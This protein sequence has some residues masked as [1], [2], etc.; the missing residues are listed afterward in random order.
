[1]NV[2]IKNLIYARKQMGLTIKEVEKVIPSISTI[3]S[4]KNKFNF[5]ELALLSEMYCIPDWI[6][7]YDRFPKEYCYKEKESFKNLE[8][9]KN[10]DTY[11][12]RKLI[13]KVEGLR[14][15]ILELKD[16]TSINLP[17]FNPPHL[18]YK[19]LFLENILEWL[20]ITKEFPFSFYKLKRSLE[21]RGVFVFVTSNKDGEYFVSSKQLEYFNFYYKEL[22]VI[23]INSSNNE[24]IKLQSLC[25]GMIELII[26]YKNKSLNLYYNQFYKSLNNIVKDNDKVNVK[27]Y[28]MLNMY[29]NLFIRS[30]LL[31]EGENINSYKAS[32][33][34]GLNYQVYQ[35][36][37]K[38]Y[39][40]N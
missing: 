35:K 19:N 12:V 14:S 6:L 5:D 23:I 13:S 25:K 40:F 31:A 32:V 3:E 29:P 9:Q 33:I 38:L 20:C 24:T 2:S 10:I 15:F 18:K 17:V 8:D 28:K 11:E 16:D 30:V 36:L 7:A 4:G 21:K 22:P 26:G 34:L 37:R 27:I 1:M 39:D